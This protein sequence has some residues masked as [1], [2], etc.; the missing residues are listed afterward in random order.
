MDFPGFDIEADLASVTGYPTS[1]P[2]IL[3]SFDFSPSAQHQNA[4]PHQRQSLNGDPDVK[5]FFITNC[6][7]LLGRTIAQV[8]LERGHLVAAC[9]REKHLGDLNVVL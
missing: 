4:T 2:S 1:S 9:A 6:G 5:V 8:A 7:S 3:P